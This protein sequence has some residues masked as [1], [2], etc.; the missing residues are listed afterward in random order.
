[1]PHSLDWL[2]A[3]PV[4]LAPEPAPLEPPDPAFAEVVPA[5]PEVPP[6]PPELDPVPAAP[7]AP[8]APVSLLPHAMSMISVGMHASTKR[9]KDMLVRA[10]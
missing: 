4:I 7:L 3:S 2:H 1:V 10:G 9:A 6:L 8:G 5:P